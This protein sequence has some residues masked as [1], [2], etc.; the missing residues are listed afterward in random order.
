[1]STVEVHRQ[2][3]GD[4]IAHTFE[5]EAVPKVDLGV[6]AFEDWVALVIFWVMALAV[7]LQF[8]TRYVLN[9]SYAWT[10]EIATYCLIGVVF[11]GSSMCVRLSRHIQ[12]DLIYRYLPHVVARALSTAID[13]IRI[14]FFGY[15]IKLVWVYIQIIGDESM[16]TINLPKDYVYYAVLAGFVLMFVRSVQVA[17]QHLRQGY[18]ILERPGAYDGFE[19]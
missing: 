3:T 13:L 9:D 2:I 10:E 12:V 7:F 8:F 19:G 5:E 4:E 14:A 11:I 18:S 6:Y 15:A 17:I 16:T 1:M